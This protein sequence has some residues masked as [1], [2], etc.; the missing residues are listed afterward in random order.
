MRAI[1]PPQA[2]HDRTSITR[3]SGQPITCLW[4]S[5]GVS[6]RSLGRLAHASEEYERR[7]R[8]HERRLASPGR[9]SAS[10]DAARRAD[11]IGTVP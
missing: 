8:P 4:T 6:V 2:A 11:I 5:S 3:S 10:S 1:D 7:H 9:S